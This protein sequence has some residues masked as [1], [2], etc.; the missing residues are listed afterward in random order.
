MERN[1]CVCIGPKKRKFR[2]LIRS[3]PIWPRPDKAWV[4]IQSDTAG[5]FG[6]T[7]LWHWSARIGFGAVDNS[8]PPRALLPHQQSH[9]GALGP[10]LSVK[11]ARYPRL[12]MLPCV[13]DKVRGSLWVERVPDAPAQT[14]LHNRRSGFR[15][16]VCYTSP[17][18]RYVSGNIKNNFTVW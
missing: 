11:G 14:N 10:E 3:E 7:V 13:K 12:R 1:G 4:H 15:H 5:L 18:T 2:S 9:S 8:S 16:E 6:H 17:H